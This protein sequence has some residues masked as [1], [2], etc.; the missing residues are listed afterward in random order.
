VAV[1]QLWDVVE[2][3]TSLSEMEQVYLLLVVAIS[4]AVELRAVEE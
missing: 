1:E 3:I 2:V 4:L